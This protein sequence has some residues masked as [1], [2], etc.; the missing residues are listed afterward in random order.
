MKKKIFDAVII[1]A[2]LVLLFEILTNKNLVSETISYS[3]NLWVTSVLPSLFPFFIISDVLISYNI[4]NYIPNIFKKTFTKLF[5]INDAQLTIFFLSCVS[6]FPSNARNTR[7]L[8]DKGI[9]TKEEASH[10]LMFTHFSNPLFILSTVAVS[11]LNQES[12]GIFILI[13]HYLGN[14]ILGLFVRNYSSVSDHYYMTNLEKSQSFSQVFLHAIRSSVDTLLMILGTL[15]CFLLVSSLMI[16]RLEVGIYSSSILR[17]ILEITMGLKSLSLLPLTDIYKVV[18]ATMFI[19]FG[20][21]SVHLQV[22]SQLVDTDI[23]YQPF[24][25]ARVFHAL[26]SGGICYLLF[27]I[28]M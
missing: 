13:S 23:P 1:L 8:Y 21:F 20:G 9:I 16:N 5:R 7:N 28:F 4:T 22:I 14:F 11:F 12:Y 15:T 6:G 18:I 26:F 27:S 24:F 2:F 25:V 3:L 10:I 17:G 19:S